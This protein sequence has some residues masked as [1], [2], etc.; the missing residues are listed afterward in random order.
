MQS[1]YLLFFTGPRHLFRRIRPRCF[2]KAEKHG[3]HILSRLRS[4]MKRERLKEENDESNVVFSMFKMATMLKHCILSCKYG[5]CPF[6]CSGKQVRKFEKHLKECWYIPV[7]CS[8]KHCL[9]TSRRHL[10]NDHSTKCHFAIE[11]C[12]NVDCN[13]KR[14]RSKMSSH[15]QKCPHRVVLCT[16]KSVGC[17]AT[18]SYQDL[19]THLK[20]CPWS[21]QPCEICGEQIMYKDQS[22]HVCP[23]GTAEC[24]Y[25]NQ[26][27]IMKDFLC[28]LNC[29]LT[30][31]EL[32]QEDFPKS[33]TRLHECPIMQCKYQFCDY[34]DRILKVE[35]HMINCPY[36]PK[37]CIHCNKYIQSKYLKLHTLEC[38]NIV[39]CGECG[40]DIEK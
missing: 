14:Q 25:C 10:M 27:F 38:N 21:S 28:H 29:C 36:E 18:M 7:K 5:D 37:K 22:S 23:L 13:V 16:N 32:C 3:E 2:V 4:L 34:K 12:P 35:L 30:K 15:V 24:P 1:I 6:S 33:K 9:Y 19:N 20:T 31:C 40:L 8:N 17:M 39:R 26:E 11:K